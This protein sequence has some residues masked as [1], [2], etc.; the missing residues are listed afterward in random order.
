MAVN[1]DGVLFGAQAAARQMRAQAKRGHT[2]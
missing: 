1:L 2:C